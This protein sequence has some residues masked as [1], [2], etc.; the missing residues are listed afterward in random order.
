MNKLKD[1]DIVRIGE[2]G[3]PLKDEQGNFKVE[4]LY[5][6]FTDQESYS[7]TIEEKAGN[8]LKKKAEVEKELESFKTQEKQKSI[9]NIYNEFGIDSNFT[10][11]VDLAIDKTKSLDDIKTDIKK[12][13]ESKP[14]LKKQEASGGIPAKKTDDV[15]NVKKES[16]SGIRE[17][18]HPRSFIG[19]RK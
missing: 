15:P 5:R 13:V 16:Q 12:L 17:G 14:S 11:L 18:I 3:Q 9:A 4:K 7:A 2:D 1:I 6:G 10:D 19:R 8:A